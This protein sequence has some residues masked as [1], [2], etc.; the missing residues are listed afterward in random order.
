MYSKRVNA[1]IGENYDRFHILVPKG[2]KALLRR[3]FPKGMTLNRYVNVLIDLDL[4]Q[5]V[6]WSDCD[7]DCRYL[8]ECADFEEG[9]G[10]REVKVF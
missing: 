1:F 5:K 10:G 6:D 7:L 3:K 2:T 4:R 9:K 8:K